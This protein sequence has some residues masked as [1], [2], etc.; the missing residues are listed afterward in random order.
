MIY[1][2]FLSAGFMCLLVFLVKKIFFTYNCSGNEVLE[3]SGVLFVK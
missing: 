2:L 1:A 3:G